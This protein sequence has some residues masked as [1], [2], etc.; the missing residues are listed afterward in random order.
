ML[1][2]N[3]HTVGFLNSQYRNILKKCMILNACAMMVC[4][5]NANALISPTQWNNGNTYEIDIADTMRGPYLEEY[6]FDNKNFIIL[7]NILTISGTGATGITEREPVQIEN[8]MVKVDENAFKGG[9]IYTE[10]YISEETTSST[11]SFSNAEISNNT[12][13]GNYNGTTS[14]MNIAGGF[15]AQAARDT[16]HSEN[17]WEDYSGINVETN[18]NVFSNNGIIITDTSSNSS[19]STI[20]SAS[21]GLFYIIGSAKIQGNTTSLGTTISNNKV[22]IID[23]STGTTKAQHIAKGG[24]VYNS[25]STFINGNIIKENQA[26]AGYAYGGAI[27]NH[28]SNKTYSD[29]HMQLSNFIENSVNATIEGKGG[30]LYNIADNK[31]TQI[32]D[33]V[34]FTGN[35]I[36]LTVSNPDIQYVAQGGAIYNNGSSIG[37]IADSIS[38]LTINVYNANV[39]YENNKI[40]IVGNTE[41]MQ[42][43]SQGGAIYNGEFG[44]L[45]LTGSS[46]GSITFSTNE[47]LEGGAIYNAANNT[48]ISEGSSSY[49]SF[50]TIDNSAGGHITFSQNNA[51]TGGALFNAVSGNTNITNTGVI[52]FTNNNASDRGGAIFNDDSAKINLTANTTG[53]LSFENNGASNGGALYNNK[54]TLNI[55][56]NSVSFTAN[57]SS[58]KGGGLFNDGSIEISTA[59]NLTFRSNSATNGGAIYNASGSNFVIEATKGTNILF[60]SN[61][62]DQGGAIFNEQNAEISFKLT[63]SVLNFETASDTIYND[64]I[65]NITADDT[66]SIKFAANLTGLGKFNLNTSNLEMINSVVNSEQQLNINGSNINISNASVLNLTPDDILSSTTLSVS[67]DS[68]IKYTGSIQTPDLVTTGN[69]INSG[70]LDLRDDVYST[71]SFDTYASNNGWYYFDVDTDSGKSDILKVDGNTTGSTNLFFSGMDGLR[72]KSEKIL[73]AQTNP[74]QSVDDY[75]FVFDT[76]SDL[77]LVTIS[78]EVKDGVRNWYIYNDGG[79]RTEIANYL[80]LPRAAVEQTRGMIIDATRNDLSPRIRYEYGNKNKLRKVV[81]PKTKISLWANPIY[82]RATMGQTVEFEGKVWGVDFGLNAN[83]TP[84]SKTGFIVSYRDGKY[85][86]EGKGGEF[87]TLGENTFDMESVLLGLYYN[88]YFSNTYF[89]AIVYGG[90]QKARMDTYENVFSST[91]AMQAGFETEVGYQGY[92]THKLTATPSLKMSYDYIKYDDFTDTLGKRVS[93]EDIHDI[94]LEAGIKF[95]Y[96]FNNE[97]QLHTVGYIKP[98]VVQLVEKGGDATINSTKFE[99]LIKN[100]TSFKMEAGL[101]AA[102]MHNFIVGGFGSYSFGSEYNALSIG[103]NIRY[104]W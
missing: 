45:T 53:I 15:I 50:F 87:Y 104:T 22:E 82:R 13:A 37:G 5:E 19:N 49:T 24:A 23:N 32:N 31:I 39:L 41:N 89:N 76:K 90:Q 74:E 21:G 48:N 80:M 52:T 75:E 62:A 65:L 61:I 36:N 56:G 58:E 6:T 2:S 12:I 88:K 27:Y 92:L 103:G 1:K 26:N 11:I 84:D 93:F 35:T 60:Q 34:T 101:E 9:F 70:I 7:N 54:S 102:L 8:K 91:S 38:G 86:K 71:V 3:N 96:R 18:T 66:S 44:S 4:M 68:I 47:A 98:S 72:D 55:S 79:V 16:Y 67:A 95:E 78:N 81:D 51:T 57:T 25:G 42:V 10:Q 100:E 99:D 29:L 46:S 94:E 77:F 73:F 63:E 17:F 28:T 64:G 40:N 33:K 20:V 69:L 14:G 30:A 97:H 43:L 59:K 85:E 83:I